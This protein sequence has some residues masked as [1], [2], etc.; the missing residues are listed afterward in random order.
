[1]RLAHPVCRASARTQTASLC[2][3]SMLA[4]H[5]KPEG[6]HRHEVIKKEKKSVNMKDGRIRKGT[7]EGGALFCELHHDVEAPEGRVRV[8]ER[9]DVRVV[10]FPHNPA[11]RTCAP[12]TSHS[13]GENRTKSTVE[14]E[15]NVMKWSVKTTSDG[16]PVSYRYRCI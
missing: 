5:F 4:L 2:T 3:A 15:R 14:G 8:D 6:N 9:H 10:E 1:M 16:W 12:G 13:N 11:S 7:R